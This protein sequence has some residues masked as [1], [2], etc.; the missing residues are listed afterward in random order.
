M[1]DEN[2]KKFLNDLVTSLDETFWEVLEIYP[3]DLK[4]EICPFLIGVQSQNRSDGALQGKSQDL[5]DLKTT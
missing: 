5:P 1:E 4:D 2:L 3:V